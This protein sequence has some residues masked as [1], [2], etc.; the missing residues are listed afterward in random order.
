MVGK[1]TAIFRWKPGESWGKAPWL[2]VIIGVADLA[3]WIAGM[4]GGRISRSML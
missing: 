1:T 3:E 4:G 2:E